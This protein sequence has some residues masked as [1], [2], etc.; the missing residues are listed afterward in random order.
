MQT[1]S[2]VVRFY[3]DSIFNLLITLMKWIFCINLSL[4]SINAV[5]KNGKCARHLNFKMKSCF[6]ASLKC[7][8]STACQII[9]PFSVKK[10]RTLILNFINAEKRKTFGHGFC[11][12]CSLSYTC[13]LW[14]RFTWRLNPSFTPCKVLY[15]K[16]A[17]EKPLAGVLD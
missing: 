9:I 8:N 1:D 5:F 13:C 15:T 14:T 2:C 6:V 11:W 17:F 12:I 4:L 16:I 3:V 7:I 10:K